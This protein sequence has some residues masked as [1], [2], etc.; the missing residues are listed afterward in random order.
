MCK[1]QQVDCFAVPIHEESFG[2]NFRTT[3]KHVLGK[4]EMT[5]PSVLLVDDD[6]AILTVFSWRLRAEHFSVTAVSSGSAAISALQKAQYDIVIT[7]LVMEGIDGFEVL[8]T[9]KKIT[10]LTPVIVISGHAESA[11]DAFRLGADEFLLKPFDIE[12]LS[13]KIRK[14]FNNLN[15][16]H[17]LMSP[18]N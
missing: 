15:L 1:A 5:Q 7:D 2:L 16:Q 9:V 8:S 4:K 17:P 11:I 14:C 12:E 18:S 3:A 6:S 10:P 13:L